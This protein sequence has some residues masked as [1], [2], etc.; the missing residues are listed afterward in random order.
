M[1]ELLSIKMAVFFLF[2]LNQFKLDILKKCYSYFLSWKIYL[3]I[4]MFD[5]DEGKKL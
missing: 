4:L 2:N 3:E 5:G 1:P